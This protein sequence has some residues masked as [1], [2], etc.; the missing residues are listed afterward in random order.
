LTQ[1]KTLVEV[2]RVHPQRVKARE[3]L[4]DCNIHLPHEGAQDTG[5]ALEIEGWA[6]GRGE[7]VREIEFLTDDTCVWR[8]ALGVEHPD[9]AAMH[10]QEPAA[11]PSGFYV[12]LNSLRL[13]QT[14]ELSVVAVLSDDRRA[15][16]GWIRGIREP[17]E[18]D[19]EPSIQPLL[20]TSL[21]RSGSTLLTA[22]LGA[23]PSACAHRPFEFEPRVGSY[24]ID[25]LL[26]L[27]DPVSYLNQL[28]PVG[29]VEA[30][31]WWLGRDGQPAAK[32]P[33]RTGEPRIG[34]WLAED[35]VASLAAVCQRRIEA[36]YEQVAATGD[37]EP[38]LF[39]E[40]Y[41]P[42]HVPPLVRELYPQAREIFLVRDFRDM[43]SS[44]LAYTAARAPGRFGRSL[45]GSDEEYVLSQVR[46]SVLRLARNWDRRGDSAHLVRYEDLVSSPQETLAGAL[47]YLELDSDADTIATM[48]QS[49][50]DHA[51]LSNS[52]RTTESATD[53]IG[54]WRRELSPEL[55]ETC[56][57][58]LG[59]AYEKF[60]YAV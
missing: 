3:Q 13:P 41:V 12:P 35:A 26:S 20:V 32:L 47:T 19:F 1:T 29:N 9:V 60:G 8:S 6:V 42:G 28:D 52:H 48:L 10:P 17:L 30:D 24:W 25:V 46:N 7:H 22:L 18:T 40:K 55:V 56:E 31:G 39:V 21:G 49:V 37:G 36:V 4:L 5:Y 27:T 45:A 2:T 16:L 53:S 44:I 57:Q 11:G 43:V 38:E 58:A 34:S 14:F 51:E 23:H 59:F 33:S 15:L 54:R 50:D